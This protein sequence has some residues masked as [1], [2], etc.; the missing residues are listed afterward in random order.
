MNIELIA[1]IASDSINR[2][3]Q[4]SKNIIKKIFLIFFFMFSFNASAIEN[5][6]ILKVDQEIIT[7]IDISN[8]VKYLRALNPQLRNL[9]K[10]T[11]L[12]IAKKS[13]IREKIKII[14]I[15]NNN[16]NITLNNQYLSKILENIFKNLNMS[17]IDEF[18]NYLDV[19][20][21]NIKMVKDKIS[22]EALWNELIFSKFSS[23]IK[24]DKEKLKKNIL[25]NNNRII[26]FYN[27]NEIVFNITKKNELEKNYQIIK[28]DIESKGFTNAALIHSVSDTSKIG[29]KLGWVSEKSI[30]KNIIKE[31]ANLNVGEFSKPIIIPGGALILKIDSIK[32]EKIDINIEKELNKVI[33]VETNKQLNQHSNLYYNKIKKNI[34][35]NEL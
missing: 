25:A 16:R 14:E 31:I 10:N 8:E 13:L 20:N 23:N 30:N 4:I 5:K 32:E 1:L 28:K 29:G 33:S 6:I 11:I 3:Y 15:S 35:I 34:D 18:K 22:I 26:K 27:L 7:N 19:N 9:D 12:N 21:L 24:I 17:S 2:D